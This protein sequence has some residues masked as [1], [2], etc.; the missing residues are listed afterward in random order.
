MIRVSV[1]RR[2]FTRRLV[3]VRIEW[4]KSLLDHLMSLIRHAVYEH[5]SICA[6]EEE[7]NQ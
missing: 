3:L 6:H 4:A 1:C 7:E 2:S 5:L